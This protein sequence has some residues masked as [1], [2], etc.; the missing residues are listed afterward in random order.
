MFPL[1][2]RFVPYSVIVSLTV[3]DLVRFVVSFVQCGVLRNLQNNSQ[4]FS[5]LMTFVY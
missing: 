3:V 4:F 5:F 1:A 2:S